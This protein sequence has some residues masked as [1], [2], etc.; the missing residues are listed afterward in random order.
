MGYTT[1][2]MRNAIK[3]ILGLSD[4]QADAYLQEMSGHSQFMATAL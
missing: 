3:S 4:E 1:G 2:E